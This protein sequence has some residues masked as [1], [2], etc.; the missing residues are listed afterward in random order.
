LLQA[1]H[2]H[3]TAG[4]GWPRLAG[5]AEHCS[6]KQHL[7]LLLLLLRL[8]L[9]GHPSLRPAAAPAPAGGHPLRCSAPAAVPQRQQRQQHH[10]LLPPACLRMGQLLQQLEQSC[11]LL[12]MCRCCC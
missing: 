7:L 3:H 5:G 6:C 12:H 1:P 11:V 2:H 9:H 10:W 4:A 8:L